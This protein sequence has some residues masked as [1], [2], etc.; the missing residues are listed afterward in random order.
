MVL[1]LVFL[2]LLGSLLQDALLWHLLPLL[3]SDALVGG[4]PD[5]A[6]TLAL[7]HHQRHLL[8]EF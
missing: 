7:L 5:Y 4:S 8:V 6:V 3:A 1:N 2:G